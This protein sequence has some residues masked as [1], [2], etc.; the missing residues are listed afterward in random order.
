MLT[1]AAPVSRGGD[2]LSLLLTG[3]MIIYMLG[4]HRRVCLSGNTTTSE[5]HETTSL[6]NA[7]LFHHFMDYGGTIRLI[8][9]ATPQMGGGW[10]L[11]LSWGLEF[12][13]GHFYLFHKGAGKL[14]FYHLRIGC[15]STKP[16]GHLFIAL[17]FQ[18]FPHTKKYFQNTPGPP[19]F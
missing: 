9:G 16:C 10:G 4:H 12:L 18:N 2:G 11:S 8:K 17:I 14:N 6:C 19:V 15:F 13:P 3:A 1:L 5:I 7:Q